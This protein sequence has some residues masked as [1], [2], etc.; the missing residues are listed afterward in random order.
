MSIAKRKPVAEIPQQ[1]APAI[2]EKSTA[3][4]IVVDQNDTPLESLVAYLDGMPW[5][6]DFYRQLHGEHNDL[7]EIDPGQNAAFQ[8]YE[9]VVGLELRVASAL[10]SSYDSEKG[11]TSVVG[12]ATIVHVVPNKNDYFIAD[13][14]QQDRGLFKITSVERRTFNTNSVYLIN[15][16]L[17]AFAREEVRSV[18]NLEAKVIRT[19]YFSKDRLAEGL[20]PV[21]REEEYRASID[22]AKHYYE[23]IHRYFRTFFNT[24][25]MTLLVPGQTQIVYDAWLVNFLMQIMDSLEAPEMRRMKIVSLDYDRYMSQ[26]NLWS[27]LLMR[28][29]SEVKRIHQKATL[30]PRAYFN[31]SSW[32]RGPVYWNI[33]RYVYPVVEGDDVAIERLNVR[34]YQQDT[35]YIE[36]TT[37]SGQT[38]WEASNFY[39]TAETTIPLIHRVLVDDYYILSE[40]F[41]KNE[42]TL[43]V[44]EI[45]I[46]D[47][48]KCQTI[49]FHM[50]TGLVLAYP[51]W[52]AL[53][54]FYYGPLLVLLMKE[55]IKGFYK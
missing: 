3:Q 44:L 51:D 34:P 23:T 4:G 5:T 38:G 35:G 17:T 36:D 42:G 54:R 43:S 10:Q 2:V 6:T 22:L 27:V 9:K 8:Q 47:Y 39:P 41:Y 32:L 45:L 16:E 20:S 53:E 13:A 30:A 48:L 28:D 29:Y 40:A 21:L 12:S 33:D 50:L 18:N 49:D 52:P 11:I 19:Y 26:G 55:S 15:Y 46:R 25:M 7:R 37:D 24:G 31:K 1:P 14:G